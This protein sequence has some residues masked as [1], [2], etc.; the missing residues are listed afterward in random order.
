MFSVFFDCVY[1]FFY[2]RSCFVNNPINLES[3]ISGH[4]NENNL[5]LADL[6]LFFLLGVCSE[7]VP[8]GLLGLNFKVMAFF[9]DEILGCLVTS[10]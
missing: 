9:T 4:E 1:K 2:T 7:Y 10:S 5:S 8:D 3:K 6:E